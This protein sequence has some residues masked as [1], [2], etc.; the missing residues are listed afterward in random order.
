VDA[1]ASMSY[2][3]DIPFLFLENHI[4]NISYLLSNNSITYVITETKIFEIHVHHIAFVA[5]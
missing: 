1:G 4:K 3:L 5:W 2:G